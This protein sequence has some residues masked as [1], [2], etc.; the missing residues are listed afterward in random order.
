MKIKF[1]HLG[2]FFLSLFTVSQL[3]AQVNGFRVNSPA[4]IAGEYRISLGTFGQQLSTDLTGTSTF[5]DDGVDIVTDACDGTIT[6]ITGKIALIDRGDCQFG[7]KALTAENAGAIAVIICNNVDGIFTPVPGDVGD[8]VSIPV[9]GMS[10][11]DCATIRTVAEGN[12]IDVTLFAGCFT[13]TYDETV[14][15]GSESGQGDFDGG[16]GDWLVACAGDTCWGWSDDPAVL[17]AGG[18]DN[19]RVV[20]TASSCNGF[21]VMDSD[22]LD[23]TGDGMSFGAGLCPADCI[24][25]I[26]SPI[27]DLTQYSDLEGIFVEFDQSVRHFQSTYEVILSKNGGVTWPDT[28]T[29]NSN[30]VTNAAETNNTV[31]V[32]APGYENANSITMQFRYTGNYYYWAIDDVRLINRAVVDMNAREDFFAT[33]PSYRVPLSQAVE[34]PFL[35]DIENLGNVS[36]EDVSVTVDIFDES[37]TNVWSTT[38]TNYATQPGGTFLNENSVFPETYTPDAVG[39]FTGTYTVNTSGNDTNTANNSVPFEFE[40]TEDILSSL[41]SQDDIN[42]I[43]VLDG[44][45]F[46]APD[47]D[48]FIPNYAIGYL[49]HL[50]NGANHTLSNVRFGILDLPATTIGNINVLLYS[51]ARTDMDDSGN[52]AIDLAADG[53]LEGVNAETIRTGNGIVRV[54]STSLPPANNNAIDIAMVKADSNGDPLLDNNNE[55]SSVDLAN[56]RQYVLVIACKS[57]S[58]GSLPINLLGY[59]ADNG[60]VADRNYLHGATNLAYDSLGLGNITGTVLENIGP[61]DGP[62]EIN[63]LLIN[64]DVVGQ[65]GTGNFGVLYDFRELYVELTILDRTVGTEDLN[66]TQAIEI[67]PNPATDR[68]FVDLALENVSKTVNVEVVDAKGQRVIS[69]DFDNV[70]NNKLEINTSQLV[71]GFYNVNVRTEEGLTSKKVMIQK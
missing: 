68:V 47:N 1:T 70:L 56:D 43:G 60:N 27:I 45:V 51:V 19:G 30:L 3:S 49:F 62:L 58:D 29:V 41:P 11:A 5:V 40:V 12:D 65:G 9:A 46:I 13:P 26:I 33:A 38:N 71:S 23:N 4:D 32:P 34:M 57:G 22:F 15:W 25:S 69:Q 44:S 31:R 64:N 54:G 28:F 66:T 36:A 20:N 61:N 6:N 14:F 18:F 24:G 8:Q 35:V 67:F 50:P 37:G 63:E 52:F 55:T 7:E 53:Q 10:M 39:R 21:M 42:M 17:A 16:P 2:F 48:F 59:E